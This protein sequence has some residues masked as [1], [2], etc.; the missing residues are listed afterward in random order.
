VAN[1]A[2]E[3]GSRR[4]SSSR[5]ARARGVDVSVQ[6]EDIL[7]RYEDGEVS[8]ALDLARKAK[9]EPLASRIAAFQAAET[10]GQ[11]ALAERDTAGALKHLTSAFLLDQQLSYGWSTQGR[12]LRKQL[13]NLH[14]VAGL[15]ELGAGRT[16][17]AREAFETALK[18]DSS[19][20]QAKSHL[21]R[22]EASAPSAK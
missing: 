12:E 7:K 22:M 10:A 6:E 13:G 9:L 8:E 18:Y 5:G 14:T 17:A 3:P 21:S 20:A 15:E 2:K 19:N 4:A 1:Q 11:K 16:A